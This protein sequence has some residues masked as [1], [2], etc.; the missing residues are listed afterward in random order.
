MKLESASCRIWNT[1]IFN[2]GYGT[3]LTSTPISTCYARRLPTCVRVNQQDDVLD[4]LREE[5]DH[6]T[7]INDTLASMVPAEGELLFARKEPPHIH[8]HTS[9]GLSLSLSFMLFKACPGSWARIASHR[10]IILV[11][12][13]NNRQTMHMHKRPH[14]V[15]QDTK[16][17]VVMTMR[18]ACCA[19][20]KVRL[21]LVVPFDIDSNTRCSRCS[22]VKKTV[23]P[24][25]VVPLLLGN[26]PKT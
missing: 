20:D 26:F 11:Q 12:S 25:V 4:D 8:T 24:K 3:L 22:S 13:A 23:S 21:S 9:A 7:H 16:K 10:T 14:H 15:H 2:T 19:C 6:V 17:I 1:C 18:G 5:Q